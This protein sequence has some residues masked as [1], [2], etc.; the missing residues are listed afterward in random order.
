MLKERF[1][2]RKFC[3]ETENKTV[4]IPIDFKL[5][6]KVSSTNIPLSKSIIIKEYA[7]EVDRELNLNFIAFNG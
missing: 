6:L 5:I 7:F 2:L 1:E 3:S 4:C